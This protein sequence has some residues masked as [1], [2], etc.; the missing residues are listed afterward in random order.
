MQAPDSRPAASGPAG[1]LRLARVLLAAAVGCSSTDSTVRYYDSA[2]ASVRYAAAPD[3]VSSLRIEEPCVGVRVDDEALVP[4]RPPNETDGIDY[5]E[6]SLDEAIQYALS[7]AKVLR[8]LGGVINTPDVLQDTVYDPAVVNTDPL[9]G[10]EAALSA[11]DTTLAMG[12]FFEKN[13]REFNNT[14]IGDGGLLIQ[15]LIDANFEL[16]KQSAT[17]SQLAARHRIE[18]DYDNSVG[19]RFGNPSASFQSILETE[20][21]QPLLRGAGVRFNRIA[22]PGSRPGAFNGVLLA[23]TRTDIGLAEFEAAV[24]DLVAN[25]ENAYW[26]LYF[27]YRDLD[28]KKRA[29]DYALE[30]YQA[31]AANKQSGRP[32]GVEEN[33]GQALEQY[34]N[35]QA[36][37]IDA[38]AGRTADGTRTGNGIGGGVGAAPVGVRLAERR[39]RLILGMPING[40]SMLRPADEPVV[41]PVVLDWPVLVQDA[42]IARP[43]LRRQRWRIKQLELELIASRN[44]LLPRLDVVGRYR[45]RGFGED[46]IS[47]SDQR[48]ASAY[49]NL[50]GGDYQEWLLGVELEAPIGFR[51]A[52]TAVRNAE[53]SLARAR[54]ILDEQQRDVVFGLT[55][56]TADLQRAFAVSQAQ[57]NRFQAARR[58]IEALQ[59]AEEAGRTTIDLVLDAQRQAL[60]TEIAYHL[61]TIDY[62]LSMRNVYYETGTLLEYNNIRLAEGRSPV[63]AYDD[64]LELAARRTRPIEHVDRG[65]TVSRGPVE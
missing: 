20:V 1:R 26:D 34:W 49:G 55:N 52:H 28:A 23:R 11:F 51:F 64:A 17:G 42:M 56:A 40:G 61:A 35:F 32:E 12:A 46:L 54:A 4:P 58:Q 33:L 21:R 53:H 45:W 24:R 15:D 19:N 47:Q 43:E 41:A 16:R 27:A 62:A 44:F 13:D 22:G 5:Q 30:T 48:F 31:I 10:E 6:I 25:V 3:T 36:A 9:T 29:R 59:R 60:D 63:G 2:A 14:F 57:Y 50:S 65:V 18:M 8:D 37:V 39:L 7:H 38:Q